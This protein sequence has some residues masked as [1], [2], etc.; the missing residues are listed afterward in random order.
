MKKRRN[1]EKF[2]IDYMF[3][4]GNGNF[5]LILM[6][7]PEGAMSA[8]HDHSDSHCFMRVLDG[9]VKEIK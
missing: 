3:D 7:W 8:I 4:S 6:C 2:N 5:N 1:R 9:D